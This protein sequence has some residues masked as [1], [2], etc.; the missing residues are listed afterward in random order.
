MEIKDK[1]DCAYFLKDLLDRNPKS[2]QSLVVMRKNLEEI[3][4]VIDN[5]LE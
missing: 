4:T 3:Q 5:E 1:L 2:V